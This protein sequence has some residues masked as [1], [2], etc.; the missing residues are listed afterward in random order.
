MDFIDLFSGA[1][2]LTE[3]FIKA[4]HNPICHIEMDKHAAKTLETRLAFHY[5]KSQNK[6]RDYNNYILGKITKKEL[7]DQIPKRITNSIIQTEI[8]VENLNKLAT[9]ICD[10]KGSKKIELIIGGPPCQAYSLAVRHKNAQKRKLDNRNYLFKYYAF[11]LEKFKPKYF[12]F[13]NVTGLISAGEY[14]REMLELFESKNY[15]VK[16]KILNSSDYGVLQSRKRVFLI[17]KRGKEDFT[18]PIIPKINNIWNIGSHLFGDLPNVKHGELVNTQKYLK[19]TNK[20]LDQF[21]YRT[22]SKF[23]TQHFSRKHNDTDLEIFKLVISAWVHQKKR[24]KYS[25][26]PH[27]LQTHKNL[28]TFQDRYKVIDPFGISHT[29]VAHISKDGNYYIHPNL[30][31]IRSITLREAAR[32]QSFSDDYYFEGPMTSIFKQIGNAVPPLMAYAIAKTIK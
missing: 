26:I 6:L 28:S 30:L 31:N 14:L 13:E 1:G 5:L 21:G 11:F 12:V 8:Q 24:I 32:I 27:R 22:N 4:G 7:L 23:V 15:S 20:Y 10:I 2:G 9:Q 25:E 18:F 3:G 29:L 16:F 19:K 17:G